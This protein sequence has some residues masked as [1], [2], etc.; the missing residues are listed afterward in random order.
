MMTTHKTIKFFLLAVA[1]LM[2][3]TLW[4]RW[5]DAAPATH[6]DCVAYWTE[7]TTTWDNPPPA[8]QIHNDDLYCGNVR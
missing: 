6:A 8:G 3:C 1:T 7:R 4:F 2:L 5:A